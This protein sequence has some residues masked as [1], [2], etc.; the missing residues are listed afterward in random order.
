[1]AKTNPEKWLYVIR[2]VAK[3]QDYQVEETTTSL[4][5]YVDHYHAAAFQ[6]KLSSAEYLQV[7]QWECDAEGRESRY[8]RAVYSIRSY[9]DAVEFCSVLLASARLRAR[10]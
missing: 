8:G 1:M 4:T 10:R 5:I 6:V 2:E 3:E 9:T 7:H